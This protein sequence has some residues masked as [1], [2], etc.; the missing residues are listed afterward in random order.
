MKEEMIQPTS[1]LIPHPSSLSKIDALF[2]DGPS[3]VNVGIATFAQTLASVGA[4]HMHLEWHPS[5]RGDGEL[6]AMLARLAGDAEPGSLGARIAEANEDAMGRLLSADPVWEDVRPAREVI[7]GMDGRLLLHA[8]PPIE[9]ERM[10][11]P[12]QGAITGAIL[13]EGWADTP[14]EAT[15]MAA[16]G[17]VRFA[18]CHHKGAVGPMAGVVS[19]S[20]PVCVV[21]N[22]TASN[23]AFATLNEGLGKVLRY[24]AYSP[25][26]L[27]RLGWMRDV[28]GPALG[29][30][31][32]QLGGIQLK[33]VI[34]QAL[35]MGDE[36]HNRNVAA[37]S[38]ISRMLAPALAA[39]VE[40]RHDL[41]RVLQFL[42]DNNHFF[43][44]LSMAACKA[45]LDAAHG[46][47]YSTL[48]TAMA[49][50]GVDFGIRV[51]GLGDR[52]FTGPAN[53]PDG[54]YFPGYSE[55]DAA[56]DLG[57]SAITETAGIGGFAIGAAPAIVKF[58]GGT[59]ED[60]LA[61][62]EE[63]YSITLGRN[64]SYSL[65]TLSF[66]G[67]PTGIDIRKV[68]DT[69]VLPLINTGIAHK[70][71]GIG[72]IGAGLVRPPAI[73]FEDALRAMHEE[74]CV[75]RKT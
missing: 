29:S 64:P 72:Q 49:R 47:P 39:V 59:P 33:S 3:V 6:G 27:A 45:S 23:A 7:P 55:A 43:L 71:P 16:R 53:I 73:C 1:S 52:W 65:P 57:D 9:W 15:A 20:M 41:S 8:G 40:D 26:V 54:L 11:G 21:R 31:L 4:P 63:M 66:A 19:P 34:A 60:A 35:Q 68:L 38:L 44:N 30:A 61:Y 75:K 10:C 13:F 62:T 70:E 42:L 14:E 56:P 12:M 17:E 22:T 32:R 25:D 28:L 24:G 48:V 36:C 51:S 58:V 67:A 5:A 37:T 2:Q 18:P 74:N 46:I 69:N 50:N